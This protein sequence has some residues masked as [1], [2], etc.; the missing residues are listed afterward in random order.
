MSNTKGNDQHVKYQFFFI[1]SMVK[2]TISFSYQAI[3]AQ[4]IKGEFD[5]ILNNIEELQ[6]AAKGLGNH[7]D[8]L[9]VGVE[10]EINILTSL[11]RARKAIVDYAFQDASIALYTSKQDLM[12]WKRL[13]QEQDYT[14]VNH[15]IILIYNV[16]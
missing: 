13:C 7:L 8:I 1:N 4:S 11:L 15:F 12:E 9:G 6:K 16:G 3:L 14:E 2:F 5:D 10:K